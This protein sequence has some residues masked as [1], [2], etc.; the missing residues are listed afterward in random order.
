M[1]KI[2]MKKMSFAVVMGGAGSDRGADGR[3]LFRTAG[4]G[5]VDAA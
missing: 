5:I 2:V 1:K 4:A 3:S